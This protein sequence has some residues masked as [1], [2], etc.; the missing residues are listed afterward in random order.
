MAVDRV[1]RLLRRTCGALNDAGV[2]Y[3]IIGGNAVAAWVST[4]DESAARTTKDVDVLLCRIDLD[5]AADALRACGLTSAE[6]MGVQMFLDEVNPNPKTGVHVV[7][8]EE[9]VRE[10]YTHAA[11]HPSRAVETPDGLRIIDVAALVAMKLQ[12]HRFIDRAHVQDLIS[13][14]LVDDTVRAT[15]P[16]DLRERLCA[17][18]AE[19]VD[20]DRM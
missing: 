8:A 15:L 3:A 9:K 17:I 19:M 14:G 4:V 12:S 13:V 18:E 5:R 7:F 2:A 6:A 1:E 16:G 20:E 10:H 11:P